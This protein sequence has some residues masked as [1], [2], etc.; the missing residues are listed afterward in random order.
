MSKALKGH[1]IRKNNLFSGACMNY[2]YDTGIGMS[3]KMVDDL[4]RIDVQNNRKGTENEPSTGLGLILC[5]D[6]IEK[7]GG[8]IW[9]E[10]LEGQGSTFYFTIP[11]HP[12]RKEKA[13]VKHDFTAAETQNPTKKLKILITEDDKTS[14]FLLTLAVKKISKEILHFK[15]GAEAV[16]VCFKHPD[17]DLILMDIAMPFLEG[18]QATRDIRQFNKDVIIIAQTAQ[19]IHGERDR[20]I[21]AGCDDFV[22]KPLDQKELLSLI[23]KH[24]NS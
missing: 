23:R 16:A 9:V 17:I 10:S 14:D 24:F 1:Q 5:K 20:A 18:Y 15:N 12:N 7:H 11:C 21:E 6:F 4:F 3:R 2:N 22:P 19:V 13:A 8:K